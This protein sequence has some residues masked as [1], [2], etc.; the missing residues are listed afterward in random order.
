MT[1]KTFKA[2][3]AVVLIG[4][5]IMLS[6]PSPAEAWCRWGCG[7]GWGAGALGFGVGALVGSALA[8]PRAVYVAPAPAYYGPPAWSPAWYRYC[9]A[10]YGPSFDRRS[11]YY[12]AV[13]GGWYFCR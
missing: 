9:R 10:T 4:S 8:G 6:L 12:R 3:T 2:I 11:G 1:Y 7:W 13:D 5:G